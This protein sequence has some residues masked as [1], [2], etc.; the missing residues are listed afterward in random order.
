M[1]DS[2]HRLVYTSRALGPL[3]DDDLARL[4]R[5]AAA[6]NAQHDVTGLLLH[7]GVRF[8]QALEGSIDAVQH[9]MGLIV[10]D[11]RHNSIA[12]SYR[13]TA[14]QR[15]FPNWAMAVRRIH[16]TASAR[17]FLD[18]MKHALVPVKDH[19]LLA[20]FIGFAVLGR[21]ELRAERPELAALPIVTGIGTGARPITG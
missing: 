16:D 5:A 15:Q 9:I 7:D 2:I 18:E 19:R 21:P 11:P 12:Y 1:P 13:G 8:I 17:L 6:T 10:D 20:M 4:E 3:D 14:S